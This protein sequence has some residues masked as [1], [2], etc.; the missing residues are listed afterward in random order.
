M[1]FTAKAFIVC[2]L[3]RRR[4]DLL[5]PTVMPFNTVIN[6][7]ATTGTVDQGPPLATL[8]LPFFVPACCSQLC[9]SEGRGQGM[10]PELLCWRPWPGAGPSPAHPQLPGQGRCPQSSPGPPEHP[11]VLIPDG[12]AGRVP[13][14]CGRK[15]TTSHCGLRAKSC[16]L[17]LTCKSP[18]KDML[19]MCTYLNCIF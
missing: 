14:E 12:G 5:W 16:Q 18:Q 10:D 2:D 9:C 11:L 7:D 15:E 3:G 1:T 6:P 8:P 4:A 19:L 13:S 17:L